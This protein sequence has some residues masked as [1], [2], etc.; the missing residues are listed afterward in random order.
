MLYTF[1]ENLPKRKVMGYFETI[2]AAHKFE[3]CPKYLWQIRVTDEEYANLKELLVRQIH[4]YNRNC[5]NRFITVR[6]ECVLYI[7]EFWRREYHEGAHSVQ[8]ILDSLGI[9]VTQELRD[10]FYESA[11]RGLKALK[12]EL[13]EGFGGRRYL[14]SM[15]YQ[16]GLPM[17][18]VTG[19]EYG[20]V[21]DRFTRGLVNRKVDFEELNLGIVASQ[22]QCL[23]DY[24][25]QLI[26]GVESAQ[27]MLMPFY[28]Q[29]EQD[30]WYIYLQELAK[31]EKIRHRQLHPYSLD[32][33]F[34]IDTVENKIYSKYV[35]KGLQRLPEAFLS[36][37]RLDHV[38]FFS[39]Q[40]RKNGQAVDTFDYVNNFCRYSV[41][42]KHPYADGDY[43]S[44][45]L[46]N[47]EE[48]YIADDLDMNIPHL[49]FRNKDGKYEL[50]NQ[51]GRSDSF[52]LIPNGWYIENESSFTVIDY[53]WGDSVIQGIDIPSDFVDN[54]IVKGTDGVITFGM[55]A[56]LYWTEIATHPL[57]IPDVIEPLYDAENS[58]FSLCYDTDDGTKSTRWKNVQFRNKWQTEWSDKPSYGEIFARAVDT[59]GN[60]VTPIKLMN[61]GD[62]FSV[63][64]QHADK[65][66]CQVKV[67]WNHGHVTTNEGT[68]KANDVWE[69]KKEDCRDQRR[70]HFT[71]IPEGN[72]LSQF[73]ISV[74]APFKDFS[75]INIYGD[76]VQSDSWVPYTDIDKYQ[77]HIVGQNIKQY[78]FGD[79]VRELRWMND[80]FY[81][82]EKGRAIKS[83]PYEGNLLILFD[84]R[85]NLRSKLERTS[86]NM[87]NAE[88][89][90]SFSLS[91][92][93]SLEFSVKDSPYRPKQIDNGR[94][95]IT[96]N[97]RIPIKFTGVLKLL[98]LEEPELE[99]LE[100]SFDEENGFYILPEDIR[101]WGKTIIIGRTRGRICPALVDLTREMDG[102]FRANNRET[103][104]S[105]IKEELANSTLGDNLWKRILG[106]FDRSQKEDIPAS[107][108]LELFCTAQ[109]YKSL[110]C[111]AFQL[112]VK[113]TDDE[114][115]EILK[116][117]LKIF[118]SDLA[119]QWYWLQPYLSGIFVQ[120][121][122]F[123]NDPM[124]PAVQD[125]YIKWSMRH[126]GEDMIAYLSALN[127]P[128]QYLSN[129]GQCFNDVLSRFTDWLKDLCVS[130]LVE[131]YGIPSNGIIADLAETI[132]KTPK[133]ICYIEPIKDDY[134][135]SNQ[136]Y[137]GE[138]V[139]LFFNTYNEP[140]TFGNEQWLFKR[141]NAVVAHINK[142]VDLFAVK[143]E[144][145][146]SI[147]FCSKSSNRH[148]IIALN[149][150]LSH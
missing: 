109:D 65:D 3:T 66:I 147:I 6:K 90:V 91:D 53:Q 13:F 88:L 95:I 100:M 69:I 75:I 11:Q 127:N 67:T 87:L 31:Q 63:S 148:F 99:P 73:T 39:V 82:F 22:S 5:S 143:D 81:I 103:A 74:K 60:F 21:W 2:L 9:H 140:N 70:I 48:P 119:F 72:S 52:L 27:F 17:K 104:I 89:K 7:A 23:K 68:K 135:D 32:W 141:V 80:K 38:P 12:L 130:S 41:I 45:F 20:G 34:R 29:N 121:S 131:S 71:L 77:Y 40:V 98:K 145:R 132:I 125:I 149:N 62:G 76:N 94:V 24:C 128:E 106:W 93:N 122:T 49:L 16:G 42:S 116:E 123:I 64:L 55:T 112:Y 46:H 138:E 137:L 44:L 124:T 83:I 113:C 85:E 61:I 19:S 1:A 84:S 120:L 133:K 136:E 30:V 102:A 92:G 37:N 150:K 115:Q 105:S 57:Y 114:E 25:N 107:S 10:E 4:I 117:K 134:I 26:V 126:E 101:P 36:D 18:L 96:G 59:N 56:S 144:I 139:A 118:S 28:C 111:M 78:S 15:L 47:Q 146:R 14:D 54:I 43:I 51:M 35:V 142:E 58:V 8:M 79:V 50:G 97:N 110:L 108:I 86:K 129:I 33:E